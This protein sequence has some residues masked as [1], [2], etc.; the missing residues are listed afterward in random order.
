MSYP[1]SQ[2]HTNAQSMPFWGFVCAM[3]MIFSLSPLAIDMYLPALPQMAEFFETR[4]DAMEASVAIYLLSF[5]LGQL[6]FGTLADKLNKN[7]LLSWGIIGFAV[8]SFIVALSDNLTWLFLGRAAQGFL[9]GTSIVVFSLI[10][11]NYSKEKNGKQKSSQIISYIMAVVV[12]APMV[13]PM[14]G[15]QILLHL[16]W[17]WIFICLGFFAFITFFTQLFINSQ[18]SS[19]KDEKNSVTSHPSPDDKVQLSQIMKGYRF[20]LTNPLTLSYMF[21]GAAS[22]AGLFAFISG[23]PFVYMSLY[24]ISPQDYSVLIALNAIAMISTNLL[25]ARRLGHIDPTIK[26]IWAGIG[27]GII[28]LYLFITASL[29]LPLPYIALGVVLY[30]AM[31]GFTSANA[32]TGVLSNSG[33][34]AGLASGLNGVMQFGLGALTS[35]II[36]LSNSVNSLPMA[37]TM[38]ASGLITCAFAFALIKQTRQGA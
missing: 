36:S 33:Q 25:N 20:V 31:L 27:L 19:N 13:A 37:F 5:A 14:I 8:A 12:V 21:A 15:S 9:G 2:T 26:L 22:F 7:R 32:M 28:G 1:S 17:Q 35:A 16:G 10:Q 38:A 30:M 29:A 6:V 4:I 3:A 24:Q 18:V 23:S 34:Y 11:Q